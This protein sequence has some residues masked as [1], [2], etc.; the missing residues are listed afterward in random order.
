LIYTVGKHI[1]I[2]FHINEKF[3]WNRNDSDSY[4]RRHDH[5]LVFKYKHPTLEKRIFY[6]NDSQF[7]NETLFYERI[8]PFLLASRGS[9]RNGN[10]TST[11]TFCHYFYGRN[12]CEEQAHRDVIVLENESVR[13]Y[14]TAVTSHRLSLD[15]DH[16]IVALRTL[17]KWVTKIIIERVQCTAHA[18]WIER[19][20]FRWNTIV[21]TADILFCSWSWPYYYYTV[22]INGLDL[23]IIIH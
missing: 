12:D 9:Q 1:F 17:A 7:H 16:L 10:V 8:A 2:V 20:S 11:P 3:K 13:G 14:R 6:N 22:G 18:A 4:G 15:F 23:N 21:F 19:I 5:R